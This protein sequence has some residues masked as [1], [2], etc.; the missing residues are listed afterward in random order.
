MSAFENEPR[1]NLTYLLEN[2]YSVLRLKC[3]NLY[4][5]L[6]FSIYLFKHSSGWK[7][8]RLTKGNHSTTVDQNL[9]THLCKALQYVKYFPTPWALLLNS[10]K[11]QCNLHHTADTDWNRH[12]SSDNIM[13]HGRVRKLWLTV[14]LFILFK[15]S[16]LSVQLIFLFIMF[17]TTLFLY[18]VCFI[19]QYCLHQQVTY[20]A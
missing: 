11:W 8:I 20:Q 7:E 14:G 17:S 6:R 16:V 12:I 10:W 19:Y 4:N 5:Y 15:C 2:C 3:H 1:V 9:S 18:F 13:I